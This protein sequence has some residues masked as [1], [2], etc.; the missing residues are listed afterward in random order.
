MGVTPRDGSDP[1]DVVSSRVLAELARSGYE[2]LIQPDNR[3]AFEVHHVHDRAAYLRDVLLGHFSDAFGQ[4]TRV[5]PLFVQTLTTAAYGVGLVVGTHTAGSGPETGDRSAGALQQSLTRADTSESRAFRGTS[6]PN[7]SF[8]YE[9]ARVFEGLIAVEKDPPSLQER[10]GRAVRDVINMIT[11][12]AVDIANA[13][14]LSMQSP[15]Q[16]PP[17]LDGSGSAQH[18]AWPPASSIAVRFAIALASPTADL[19]LRMADALA[20][21]C[22]VRGFG[23][24]LADTRST[25][26][27]G[28]WYAICPHDDAS[29]RRSVDG[30]GTEETAR[31]VSHTLP[32]TIVGPARIGSTMA[33]LDYL[34]HYPGIGVLACSATTIDDIAFVHLQLTV[35]DLPAE[36]A[37]ALNQ[38][39]DAAAAGDGA[40]GDGAAGGGQPRL[41]LPTALPAMLSHLGSTP[42][43]EPTSAVT[44]LMMQRAGDYELLIGPVLPVTMD[45]GAGRGALWVSWEMEGQDAELSVPFLALHHALDDLGLA[46]PAA[47]PNVE[48]LICRRMRSGALRGKG[49]LSFATSVAESYGHD[50]AAANLSALASRLEY[51]WRAR[52]QPQHRI[53]ELTVSWREYWL[54]H[55]TLPLD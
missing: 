50:Q 49:K 34:S 8:V 18:G 13:P 25:S 15:A 53:R 48:Y 33:L 39:L 47:M 10:H 44:A 7:V 51:A 35:D 20:D 40:A 1:T 16:L 9:A 19:R 2:A 27:A 6:A 30:V 22:T 17:D 37:E 4:P 26:R 29:S 45:V 11:R 21:F 54:G 28:N 55:W 24:W 31:E 12:V 41:T 23:L 36:D 5:R 14:I 52:A 32:I 42:P 3:V 38:L 43:P 46:A